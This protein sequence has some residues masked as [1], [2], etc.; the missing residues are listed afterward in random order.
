MKGMN[1]AHRPRALVIDDDV[2][3]REMVA[4]MLYCAGYDAEV[5]SDADEALFALQSRTYAVAVCDVHMPRRDGLAFARAAQRIRPSTPVVLMTSFG[6][7]RTRADGTA[8]GA[9]GLL[10]KPFSI[11]QLREAVDAALAPKPA[12]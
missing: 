7:D 4:S 8:A 5:A 3:M 2:A 6:C 10:S 11:R 9:V 1:L 12:A